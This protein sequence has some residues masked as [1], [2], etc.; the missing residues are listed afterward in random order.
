MNDLKELKEQ[1]AKLRKAIKQKEKDIDNPA[2]T[3]SILSQLDFFIE[4]VEGTPYDN[5]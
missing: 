5:D 1:A 3:L 4:N 2:L